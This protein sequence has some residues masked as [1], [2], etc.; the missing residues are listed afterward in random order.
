M[1]GLSR[2]RFYELMGTIFPCPVYDLAT[3]RPFYPCELQQACLEVRRTNCGIDSKP[4]LFYRRQGA[5][6]AAAPGQSRRKPMPADSRYHGLVEG[7][8]SLGLA[9]VT[10][11][12]VQAAVQELS[13][14]GAKDHGEVLR[15]LF[16]H[17]RRQDTS[18]L[19]EKE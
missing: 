13:L 10:T 6:L 12:Q 3:R 15:L 18:S 1:V 16:L 11:A 14:A 17:L 5:V 19:R 2:T 8:R 7:L 4:V 9:S